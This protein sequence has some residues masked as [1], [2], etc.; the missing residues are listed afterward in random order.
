MI[1]GVSFLPQEREKSKGKNNRF[2]PR[3]TKIAAISLFPSLSAMPACGPS[4]VAFLSIPPDKGWG[5]RDFGPSGAIFARGMNL[6]G[7]PG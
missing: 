4:F 2:V 6:R 7:N 1:P 3:V 5:D